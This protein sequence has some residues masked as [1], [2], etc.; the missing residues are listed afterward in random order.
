[1]D[2][3]KWLRLQWDRAG[4]WLCVGAGAVLLVVGW[5]GV[6]GSAYPAEQLPYVI[7][8]GVGGVFLL[9]LGAMLWLSADLR[10]EWRK[11]DRI[12]Q[13]VRERGVLHVE[14]RPAGQEVFGPFQAGA[15]RGVY[16]DPMEV[17]VRSP[18]Q[19]PPEPAEAEPA[20]G[21]GPLRSVPASRTPGRVRGSRANGSVEGQRKG[22]GSVMAKVE[23]DGPD[24]PGGER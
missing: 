12:E 7:S 8:G 13:A 22:S 21:S 10:D 20:G 2:F 16:E 19:V 1:M 17:P 23:R 18:E 3:E 9:G 14:W 5:V 15:S 11:L 24:A 4:A 6:S